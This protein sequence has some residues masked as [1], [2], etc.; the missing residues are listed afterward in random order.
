MKNHMDFLMKDKN[1]LLVLNTKYFRYENIHKQKKIKKKKK[2][3]LTANQMFQGLP[4][5]FPKVSE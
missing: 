5:T 4:L 1:I 2:K 3:E